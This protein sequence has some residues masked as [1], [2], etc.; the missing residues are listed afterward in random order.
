M[1]LVNNE[2]ITL[3]N[4]PIDL[5]LKFKPF[6]KRLI[7]YVLKDFKTPKVDLSLYDND[8]SVY[9]FIEYRMGREVA[10]YFIDP[11]CRGITAGNSKKLSLISLFP[12]MLRAEQETGSVIRGSILNTARDAT[13][14]YASPLVLK[15]KSN[16]WSTYTFKDGLQALPDRLCEYMLAL[17]G[18]PVEIYNKSIVNKIQFNENTRKASINISTDKESV[19]IEADH[20]FSS[21]P[22]QSLAKVLPETQYKDLCDV[23][24]E[25]TTVHMA[26]VNLEFKGKV[27]SDSAG[28]GFLVP[29]C[30]DSK[31]LGVIY[32][33]CVTPEFNSGHDITR[34]TVSHQLF[35][36]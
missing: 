18:N 30:E 27:M 17:N 21:I 34:L 32:D 2:L 6:S 11:L 25:I 1:I 29:S 9:D 26:V 35:R 31:I 19:D 24:N 3:P 23:L 15:A 7:H 22:S 28:F 5:F 36:T 16:H 13:Q 10:D 14:T 8:I 12:Q 33:S 20:I 4:R